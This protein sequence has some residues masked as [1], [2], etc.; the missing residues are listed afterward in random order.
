MN[1]WKYVHN[2]VVVNYM[3]SFLSIVPICRKM[4]RHSLLLQVVSMMPR[5]DLGY[6]HKLTQVPWCTIILIV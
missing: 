4:K 5:S 1:C 3:T 2:V 6:N